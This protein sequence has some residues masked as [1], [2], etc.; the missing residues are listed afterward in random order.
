MGADYIHTLWCMHI[1]VPRAFR[2]PILHVLPASIEMCQHQA[3][4]L[5]SLPQQTHATQSAHEKPLQLIN[6]KLEAL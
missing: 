1:F 2:W 5:P 6:V 4:S 3:A